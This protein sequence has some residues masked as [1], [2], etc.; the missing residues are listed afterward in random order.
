MS[1][2]FTILIASFIVSLIALIGVVLLILKSD[3]ARRFSLY[4]ISFA[5]G[6]LLGATFFE[7]LPEAFATGI[8]VP[9]ILLYVLF[10]ILVFFILEKLFIWYHCHGETCV[11]HRQQSA[12]LILIGDIVHNFVDG[13]II[14]LAFLVDINLGIITTVVVI[15]HEIPQEIGDFSILIFGGMTKAKALTW[16]F[17]TALS[18]VA[19][20]TITYFLSDFFN[21]IIGILLALIAGH[22]IYIAT[23]D[24]IPELHKETRFRVSFIQISLLS[25]GVFIIWIM[26]KILSY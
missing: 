10:G 4:F 3:I 2:F 18:V 23:A 11:A 22:F 7:I 16:N 13:I 8:K 24:L 12:P 9:D 26:G 1:L 20:A 15:F 14:A 25:L 6:A 21:G 17:I 5:A 19:G